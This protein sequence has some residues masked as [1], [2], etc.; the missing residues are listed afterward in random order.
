MISRVTIF[1]IFMTICISDSA[2]NAKKD[3]IIKTGGACADRCPQSMPKLGEDCDERVLD[4]CTC[5]YADESNPYCHLQC[6]LDW[7]WAMTCTAQIGKNDREER[8]D[9]D[10]KDDQDDACVCP[11]VNPMQKMDNGATCDSKLWESCQKTCT[12]A[13]PLCSYSCEDDNWVES[14]IEH[15]EP[16][17]TLQCLNGRCTLSDACKIP[18]D[19][20]YWISG[21]HLSGMIGEYLLTPDGCTGKCTGCVLSSAVQTKATFIPVYLSLAMLAIMPLLF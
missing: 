4:G 2:P 17:S 13:N 7:K 10:Q 20:G 18:R 1:I 16:H 9:R 19:G 21:E 8:L 15:F 3:E 14:C 11:N 6:S 5:T 12:Y